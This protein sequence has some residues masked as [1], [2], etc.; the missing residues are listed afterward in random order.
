MEA[1]TK[2]FK[3]EEG[4]VV[5]VVLNDGTEI[6]ADLVVIGAGVIPAVGFVKESVRRRHFSC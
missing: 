5:A 2:E 3:V 1:T 4:K 6:P